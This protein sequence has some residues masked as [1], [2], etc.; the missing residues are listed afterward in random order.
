[1]LVCFFMNVK[2]ATTLLNPRK[3]IVVYFVVMEQ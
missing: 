1:M 2:N 3:K